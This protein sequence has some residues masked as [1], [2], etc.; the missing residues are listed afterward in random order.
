MPVVSFYECV[1][2]TDPVFLRISNL[3]VN[4]H[5]GDMRHTFVSGVTALPSQNYDPGNGQ[6]RFSDVGLIK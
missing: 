1:V 3:H 4:C 2:D 5:T 6:K